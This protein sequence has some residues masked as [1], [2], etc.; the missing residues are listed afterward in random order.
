M[1]DERRS[2]GIEVGFGGS[3][4]GRVV[5]KGCDSEIAS[6]AQQGTY[7]PGRV[8]V[9]YSEINEPPQMATGLSSTTDGAFSLLAP[10]HGRVLVAG[11]AIVERSLKLETMLAVLEV[12]SPMACEPLGTYFVT[13]VIL[14]PVLA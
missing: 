3:Q 14:A 10:K 5:T 11:A 7:L 1:G 12:V 4:A 2:I 13:R 8:I 9:V 6:S